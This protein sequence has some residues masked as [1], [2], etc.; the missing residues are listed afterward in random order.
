MIRVFYGDDRVTARK[1]IDRQLGD[2]YEI[3]EGESLTVGDMPSVLLGTSLFA[4]ER[5]ILV[6]DLSENKECWAMLP[7]FIEECPH[8]IVIWE[9]KL[10]KRSA[11]YKELSK[12]KNVE[13]KEFKLAEDPDKKLVFDI[14]DM[15]F[16][17]DGKSAVKACEKIEL[18]NDAFMF[19]GLMTTQTI[20]KLQYNN[21]KAVRAIKILAETDMDMK[22]SNLEPWEAVKIALLKIGEIR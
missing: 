7:Q 16:R 3:I 12:D 6:K 2:D 22:T 13:F 14:L 15:A 11:V 1:Q 10:D 4:T 21:P 9:T 18:T 5:N 17:G 19:V 8:N 20:K